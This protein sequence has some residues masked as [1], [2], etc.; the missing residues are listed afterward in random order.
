MMLMRSGGPGEE[1][2]AIVLLSGRGDENIWCAPGIGLCAALAGPRQP[3]VFDRQADVCR[4]AFA[5]VR[6]LRDNIPPC[7]RRL[8]VRKHAER[9]TGPG[10]VGADHGWQD[11]V[12][13]IAC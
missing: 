7:F 9:L 11:T 1:P 3:I 4:P 10:S 12:A 13:Q 6:A 2:G 5:W 8:L